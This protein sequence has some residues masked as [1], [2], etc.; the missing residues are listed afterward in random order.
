M[1]SEASSLYLLLG[2]VG[3]QLL[4]ICGGFY[5]L[6]L[7]NQGTS[8]TVVMKCCLDGDIDDVYYNDDVASGTEKIMGLQTQMVTSMLKIIHSENS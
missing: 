3:D 1:R 7:N 5:R 6:G 4:E 2:S 8:K